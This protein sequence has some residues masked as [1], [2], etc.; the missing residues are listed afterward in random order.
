M[1]DFLGLVV[2]L[3]MQIPALMA[4]HHEARSGIGGDEVPRQ[5]TGIAHARRAVARMVLIGELQHIANLRTLHHFV[6]AKIIVGVVI[7]RATDLGMSAPQR[8]VEA[9]QE[10][11]ALREPVPFLLTDNKGNVCSLIYYQ[12]QGRAVRRQHARTCETRAAG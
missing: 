1:I 2:L 12:R 3:G 4:N 8:T 10:F 9:L 11:P 5:N 7:E 6:S